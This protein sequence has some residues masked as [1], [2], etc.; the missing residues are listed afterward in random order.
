MQTTPKPI[1]FLWYYWPEN[2]T[3]ENSKK[4]FFQVLNTTGVFK[5]IKSQNLLFASVGECG[6]GGGG[7]GGKGC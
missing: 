5:T 7:D 6:A 1:F 4:Y 3:R 2:E